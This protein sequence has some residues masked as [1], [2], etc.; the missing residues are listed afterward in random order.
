MTS[1]CDGDKSAR[2]RYR[3]FAITKGLLSRVVSVT[4]RDSEEE[5]IVLLQD[6]RVGQGGNVGI[7][8]VSSVLM[9]TADTLEVISMPT[10]LGRS[11]HLG[12]NLLGKSLGE[13][14]KVDTTSSS[15]DA[16]GLSLGELLDVA[17]HR[18][19]NDCDLWCHCE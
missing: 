12:E 13:L 6:F 10:N 15:S 8:I 14:V 2:G 3:T 5:A 4:C 18:P 19:E 17:V 9:C 7:L 1:I 11:V 16:L